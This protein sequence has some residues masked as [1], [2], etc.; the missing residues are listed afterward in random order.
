MTD[1]AAPSKRNDW[2]VY[3]IS[4]A[5]I[6]IAAT[7]VVIATIMSTPTASVDTRTDAEHIYLQMIHADT[8]PET[9]QQT[10]LN[11]GYGACDDMAETGVRAGYRTAVGKLMAAREPPDYAN[12][13][14]RSAFVS[15]LCNRR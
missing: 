14:V 4:A 12:L 6:V 15:G 8:Y 1:V 11:L 13:L 5:T 9:G 3:L 10:A 2:A 7:T